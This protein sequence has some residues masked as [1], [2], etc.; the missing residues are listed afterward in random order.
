MLP[1]ERVANLLDPG[2]PFLELS[3]LAAYGMY[4]GEVPAA[5][6][7]TGIGRIGGQMADA[8]A[9][10]P[11]ASGDL[12]TAMIIGAGSASWLIVRDLAARLPAMVLPRWLLHR[13]SPIAVDDVVAAAEEL[14]PASRR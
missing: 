5:G 4:G 13:S 9:R 2:S 6:I 8:M 14:L 12:R 3:Q 10:Q 11:E 7:I 1:R